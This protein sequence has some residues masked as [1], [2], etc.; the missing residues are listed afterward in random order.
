LDEVKRLRMRYDIPF[1]LEHRL[2]ER[3]GF[4]IE[5]RTFNECITFVKPSKKDGR[6]TFVMGTPKLTSEEERK[7]CARC[8]SIVDWFKDPYKMEK[9][10]RQRLHNLSQALPQAAR[11]YVLK[12]IEENFPEGIGNNHHLQ[13]RS[14]GMAGS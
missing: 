13:R 7:L 8:D 1:W 10:V 4:V 12:Y 11:E 5:K 3:F 9:A 2:V 6:Q 14:K